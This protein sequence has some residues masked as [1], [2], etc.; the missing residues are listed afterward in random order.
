MKENLIYFIETLVE[1]FAAEF[2]TLLPYWKSEYYN[3]NNIN[4]SSNSRYIK[5]KTLY[6]DNYQLST[7]NYQLTTNEV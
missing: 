3:C 4:I 2:E 6:S 7:I 5:K 1:S